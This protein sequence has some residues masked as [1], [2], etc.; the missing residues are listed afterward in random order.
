MSVPSA[1]LLILDFLGAPLK[2]GNA[3]HAEEPLSQAEKTID[4]SP[5]TSGR[6]IAFMT[7]SKGRSCRIEIWPTRY[8]TR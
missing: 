1:R 2:E 4:M 7:G 3:S 5:G 6:R 8:S